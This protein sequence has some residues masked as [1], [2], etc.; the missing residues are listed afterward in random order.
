MS[1]CQ[2]SH[3]SGVFGGG[4][5]YERSTS[6][7]QDIKMVDMRRR[8]EIMD[9]GIIHYQDKNFVWPNSEWLAL[10]LTIIIYIYFNGNI[11]TKNPSISL[12]QTLRDDEK[13]ALWF[14]RSPFSNSGQSA[15]FLLMI[16]CGRSHS[17]PESF[18]HIETTCRSFQSFH[19]SRQSSP[20]FRPWHSQPSA[21]LKSCLLSR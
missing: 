19:S 6:T 7:T 13:M 11:K 14:S 9:Y 21:N 17:G 1:R 12:K 18:W 20:K 5:L 3:A 10:R 15:F 4:G 16:F 2:N 8:R